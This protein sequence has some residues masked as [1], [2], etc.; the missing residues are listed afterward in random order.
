MARNNAA[1][2][3]STS[4]PTA[5][6]GSTQEAAAEWERIVGL[7]RNRGAL[8]GLDQAAL[9]DYL[10]CWQRVQECERDIEKRGVLIPGYRGSKVKNPSIQIAR[11][12]REA[13]LSWARELGFTIG[14]RTRLAMPEQKAPRVNAF[15][16]LA[17][18]G[19]Q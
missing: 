11:Q 17:S 5:P 2:S 6:S 18:G 19:E 14:S 1:L 13:M 3:A 15:A 4:E 8:D 10:L 7:L 9:R 16:S 12:Y